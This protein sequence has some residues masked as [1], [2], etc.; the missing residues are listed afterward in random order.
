MGAAH[1]HVLFVNPDVRDKSV[2]YGNRMLNPVPV[3]LAYRAAMT[4]VEHRATVLDENATPITDFTRFADIDLVAVTSKFFGERRTGELVRGFGAL[5]TPVVVDGYFPSYDP[6]AERIGAA[7]V[8][9]GE[10]EQVWPRILEDAS[11]GRLRPGYAGGPVDLA[12]LPRYGPEHLPP[13]DYVFPVE[14]TRGCPF[15]CN[16][17]IETRYHHERFRTRPIEHVL[18]QI[19]AR[20]GDFV[21]FSD[22][23]IVGNPRY[24]RTLFA[25]LAPRQVLWGSQ[26]TITIAQRPALAEAAGQAGCMLVFLGLESVHP[27]NL[28]ASD[29]SWSRPADYRALI[30][31]LHGAGI[32]VIGSFV[33]GFAGDTPDV[34]ERTLEFVVE[35]EIEICHFNP[36]GSGPGVPLHAEH[37]RAGRMIDPGPGGPSHLRAAVAP[38]S[39]TVRQLEEG[40]EYLY[41]R[42]YSREL[43]RQRLRR[44]RADA[45]LPGPRSAAKKRAVIGLNLA[46]RRAVERH[47][48]ATVGVERLP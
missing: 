15:S 9:R 29:K 44:Y 21:Q 40:L 39:M 12:T 6:Q 48:G 41:T 25:E 1:M 17:C 28:V 20:S 37:L 38:V 43:T 22:I 36:L 26:A 10:V 24:A 3:N 27:Q 45:D 31:R 18:A 32:G 16:F 19:D 13:H 30:A 14:A 2:I 8:V 42:T 34:F 33:F 46:Y 11:R 47:Y 5:G 7:S 35:N 4:A 23:N